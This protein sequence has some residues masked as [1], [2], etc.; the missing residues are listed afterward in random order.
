MSNVDTPPDPFFPGIIFNSDYFVAPTGSG[1]GGISQSFADTHYLKSATGNNAVSDATSTI[2]NNEVGINGENAN[3]MLTVNGAATIGRGASTYTSTYTGLN[4][5]LVVAN[6]GLVNPQ[7]LVIADTTNSNSALLIGNSYNGGISY[8]LIQSVLAGTDY[9]TLLLNPN[10]GNVGVG[11][12]NPNT[13]CK[14]TVEGKITT[15][16][17]SSTYNNIYSI[18][19]AGLIIADTGNNGATGIPQQLVIADTANTNTALLIGINYNS[20]NPYSSIQTVTAGVGYKPLA[21]NSIAGNV[22][23]GTTNPKNVC[24]ITGSNPCLLR[25]DTNNNAVGQVSGIEF[26]IPNFDTAGTAK[27]TSTSLSGNVADLKF[28]TS[29]GTNN[30]TTKMTISGSGIVAIEKDLQCGI[31]TTNPNIQLGTLNNNLSVAGA[32]GAFSTSAAIGDMVIR[33]PNKLLLLSGGGV[34]PFCINTNNFIQL[35]KGLTVIP[36]FPVTV[37]TN[38]STNQAMASPYSA[39]IYS[40]F[41]TNYAS[42]NP[43]IG[44][45][46]L[47]TAAYSTACYFY[48]DRRIK[49]DFEPIN[50]SLEI[51][52]KINLTTYKYIDYVVKG[53]MTNYGI[54]AQEVEEVIPEIINTHKDFIPNIYKNADSYDGLNTIYIDTTDITIGD[55]IKIYNDTNQEYL[56]DVVDIGDNY[57]VIENPIENYKQDTLLFFYGKEI[58]DFKNVNYDA[59]FVINMRAT[60]ELYKRL[61]VIETWAINMGMSAPI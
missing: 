32:I 31:G 56:I 24:H 22:G 50:N 25:V 52:E 60:Q 55:K 1:G 43:P 54:I 48:S 23:I 9:K 27:I 28:N 29:S 57:I 37:N 40:G 39:A 17:S 51:L 26:G 14:L 42:T 16:T 8:S 18:N 10:G 34:A 35:G 15:G 12:T 2:F 20:G 46:V 47:C 3:F 21:I 58:P 6:T 45:G 49:K 4:T 33:T 53:N 5:G 61:K 59:L 38:E 44:F 7:Q 30:S 19:G 13:N 36:T 41:N 11:T